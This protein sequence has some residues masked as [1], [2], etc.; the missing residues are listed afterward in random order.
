MI[1]SIGWSGSEIGCGASAGGRAAAADLGYDY[2]VWNAEGQ[3]FPG[4]LL[5]AGVHVS[6]IRVWISH[7]GNSVMAARVT[8]DH[9]VQV[10]VLVPQLFQ[11][12]GFG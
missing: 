10:R 5:T 7:L 1:E 2:A 8:L 6:R 9:L 11:G 3:V 12:A 4:R